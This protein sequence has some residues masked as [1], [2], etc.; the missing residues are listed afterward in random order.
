[1]GNDS[2]SVDN[3]YRYSDLIIIA[4]TTIGTATVTII[5][6]MP[7]AIHNATTGGGGG[8]GGGGNNNNK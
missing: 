5:K 1:M 8:G 2:E 4:I 3:A 7:M 6:T